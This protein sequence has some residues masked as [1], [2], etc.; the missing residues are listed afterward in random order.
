VLIYDSSD[1]L[2]DKLLSPEEGNYKLREGNQ[3]LIDS[4]KLPNQK[5]LENA[6]MAKGAVMQ[7]SEFIL[8]LTKLIPGLV[9]KPGIPGAVAVYYPTYDE[10]EGKTVLKYVAGFYIDKP[11]QEFSHI[12]T[13]DKGLAHREVR[14]WRSVLLALF[15]KGVVTYPQCKAAFGEPIGQRNT[16]WNEQTR[17]YRA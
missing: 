13:D 3:V 14:G 8:R 17:D 1:S 7:P 11:L 15:N 16:L 2:G 5:L 12:T 6:D 10:D 4:K 9:V